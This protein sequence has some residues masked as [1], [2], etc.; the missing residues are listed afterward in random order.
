MTHRPT[1]I[2]DAVRHCRLGAKSALLPI[3][4]CTIFRQQSAHHWNSGAKFM[5][6]Q[7][8]C[9][10]VII[11]QWSGHDAV[12]SVTWSVTESLGTNALARSLGPVLLLRGSCPVS[13]CLVSINNA[14]LSAILLGPRWIVVHSLPSS[15]GIS[16]KVGRW[17]GVT[18]G[19][20]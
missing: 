12:V 5:Q 1:K 2:L 8:D 6:L 13:D 17:T 16:E 14:R 7:C 18:P 4:V 11:H 19:N 9:L 15:R 20:W 10:D 3:Y